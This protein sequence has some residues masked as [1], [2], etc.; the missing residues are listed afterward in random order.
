MFGH[1]LAIAMAEHNAKTS[2]LLSLQ[3][4]RGTM[5]S[6]S[7]QEM[8]ERSLLDPNVT[9]FLWL[10]SDMRFPHDLIER[11]LAHDK[12]FVA[13]NCSKRVH[14][15]VPTAFHLS[16]DKTKTIRIFPDPEKT[17]LEKVAGVGTAVALHKREVYEII[18][19]PWFA[20]P[21]MQNEEGT[22][23][24]MVGEDMY[25]CGQCDNNDVPIYIDHDLSWEIGH[26][27]EHE[28]TMHTVLEDREALRQELEELKIVAL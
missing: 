26:I 3:I 21:W 10:D 17:G 24:K 28:F 22:Q 25:L 13:A 8:V 11:L 18:P 12:L 5:L 20:N 1:D 7:R 4:I 6:R 2:D 19:K 27:G 15:A 9:H 14:P 16:E 23:W